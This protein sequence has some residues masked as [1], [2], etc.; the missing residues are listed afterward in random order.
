MYGIFNIIMTT[1]KRDCT[2]HIAKSNKSECYLVI[3]NVA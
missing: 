3:V 2:Q 1:P